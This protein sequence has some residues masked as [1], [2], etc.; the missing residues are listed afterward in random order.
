LYNAAT[1]AIL[2]KKAGLEVEAVQQ[3]QRYPL[4]N[5]LYWLAAG[6]PGGHLRWNFLNDPALEDAYRHA[7]SSLGKCDTIVGYLVNKD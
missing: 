4:S 7:L 3:T 2:A 5:H 6:K 1:L